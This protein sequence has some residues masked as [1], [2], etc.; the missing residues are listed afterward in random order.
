MVLIYT[1]KLGWYNNTM[2]KNYFKPDLIV[3]NVNDVSVDWIIQHEID[4][5]LLDV[6]NTLVIKGNEIVDDEI[7]KWLI[8][9]VN[10]CKTVLICSNNT[11]RL[12]YR[13]SKRYSCFGFNLALKPFKYSVKKFIKENKINYSQACIMGDQV[14]TDIWLGKRFH[15]YTVLVQSKHKQDYGLTKLVRLF[16]N[17]L[18][19]QE[20][21]K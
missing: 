2:L 8:H 18:L 21:D 12:A 16:E 10:N 1:K 11:S 5:V 13:L 3:K 7:D 14:F 4:F 9:L 19:E 17:K 6:D 15:F 20:N